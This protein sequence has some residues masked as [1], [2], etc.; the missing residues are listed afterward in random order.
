MFGLQA[1]GL[2]TE[3][4]FSNVGTGQLA[5]GVPSHTYGPVRPG[6]IKYADQNNDGIINDL[7]RT[8]IGGTEDPQI[9]YGF[10]ANMQYKNVDF[11]FFFQGNALTDRVIGQ[12]TTYFIPG[13]G[14]GALG[15][16]YSNVD[17]RW[18][19]DNPSQDVFWPRLSDEVNQNNAQSSSWW[20][21]DMSML[22]LKTVELG[23]SLKNK[24]IGGVE[25]PK[26]R[27]FVRGDNLLTISE[28]DLWD[29][30]IGT[31]NGFK[32]PIMKAYAFGASI[33]F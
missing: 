30:E 14:A 31:N 10:G 2:F 27:I 4:D 15:N 13:S 25:M 8:A 12:G 23:Y 16:F 17:D 33:N 22:R 6:D 32:Y 20:L 28:F 21:R 7:D 9:I 18:T 3:D 29:P 19:A 1:V 5:T 24:S 11:G 26:V